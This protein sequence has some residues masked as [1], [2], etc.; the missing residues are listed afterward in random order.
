MSLPGIFTAVIT[1][2]RGELGSCRTARAMVP[3]VG[4]GGLDLS[5][6]CAA[7]GQFLVDL[8]QGDLQHD[9]RVLRFRNEKP[10]WSN[11]P[12]KRRP[13]AAVAGRAHRPAWQMEG[14]KGSSGPEVKL[15]PQVGAS[16]AASMR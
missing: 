13:W 10:V 15:P 3:G 2:I 14:S 8:P 7:W 5:C 4:R 16:T 1:Y 11:L 9:C 12:G 6:V